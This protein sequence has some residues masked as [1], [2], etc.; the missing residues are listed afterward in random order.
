MYRYFVETVRREYDPKVGEVL[1]FNEY[2]RYETEA[3]AKKAVEVLNDLDADY[4]YFW[5]RTNSDY[6]F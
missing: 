6:E 4:P 1:A 5:Y 2:A 3:E